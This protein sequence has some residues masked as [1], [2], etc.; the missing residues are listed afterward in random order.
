M[1]NA[2]LDPVTGGGTAERTFH[3]ARLL[4][5]RGTDVGVLTLDIGLTPERK[6]ALA[7][8]RLTALPCLL[9]RFYLP[10]PSLDR[11]YRAVAAAD[12]VHVMGH[13]TVINALAVLAAKRAGKPWVVCPAGA[14]PIVGRSG[15][16]KRLY[17]AVIGRKIVREAS[18]HVAITTDELLAFS[19]YGVDP[20]KVVVIP[21]GVS[22]IPEGAADASAF[23]ARHRLGSRGIILFMGRL[24]YIKGPDLL[25]EAFL[26]AIDSLPAHDLVFAG[27]DDGLLGKLQATAVRAGA[28]GRVRFVGYVGGADKEAAYAASDLL[29]VPSRK[30][31][32]SL[33]AIEAGI[34]G[35]PVLLTDQCGFNEVEVAGGGRV[36]P[37]RSDALG[38]ALVSLL[39]DREALVRRG[40]AMREF[41]RRD[42]LWDT[43][44]ARYL[45]LFRQITQQA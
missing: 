38:E 10:R 5:E 3:L 28:S 18:G 27:P 35:K 32:M 20:A 1:V 23:R 36:V 41:V 11:I 21:N 7:D 19:S 43:A 13:W 44:V 8:V 45:E 25:L 37:A 31:A 16:L 39:S 12:V 6:Q 9:R 33:V 22:L 4:G 34:R 17:N 29:V 14:L 26:R 30:E 42:Y 2:L 40:A 24:S 15:A